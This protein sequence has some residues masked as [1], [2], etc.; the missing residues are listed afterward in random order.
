MAVKISLDEIKAP[1]MRGAGGWGVVRLKKGERVDPKHNHSHSYDEYVIMLSGRCILKNAGEETLYSA[2]D[3]GF[4][5]RHQIHNGVVA[6]ED[7]V[8]VWTSGDVDEA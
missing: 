1:R 2:G 5:P 4:F 6:L 8:Y 7:T 3:I